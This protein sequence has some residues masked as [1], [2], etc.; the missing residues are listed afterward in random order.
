[1]FFEVLKTLNFSNLRLIFSSWLIE[2]LPFF[3]MNSFLILLQ[4]PEIWMYNSFDYS[5]TFHSV[6]S[7]Y[8]PILD[9]SSKISLNM[10]IFKKLILYTNIK[11]IL[12]KSINLRLLLI[13][14]LYIIFLSNLNDIFLVD[15]FLIVNKN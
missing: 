5:L 1:M 4:T 13:L 14:K 12:F 10:Q 8:L 6:S 7:F 9:E 15:E 2:L 3:H 11:K